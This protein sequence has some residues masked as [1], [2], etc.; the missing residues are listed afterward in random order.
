MRITNVSKWAKI[1][2]LNT[3][4]VSHFRQFCNLEVIIVICVLTAAVGFNLAYLYS[5]FNTSV[6]VSLGSD[7]VM[8]LLLSETVVS[9]M[10]EGW[11]VTD[12]WEGSMGMG[13]PVFHYYQHL[14]HLIVG[15][16]NVV[17]FDAISVGN[18]L[19][20]S[21]Y[22]LISLFPLSMY[23]SLRR[24]GFDP[25]SSAMGGLVASLISTDGTFGFDNSSYI[26]TEI[27]LYTQL[28]GMVLLPLALAWGYRVLQ[29]G[30]GYFWAVAFLSA[31]SMSHL[32]YGYMALLTLGVFAL[33]SPLHF[34]LTKAI[35]TQRSTRS[36][37]RRASRRSAGNQLKPESPVLE[38]TSVPEYIRIQWIRFAILILLVGMVTSYFVV[39]FFLDRTYLNISILDSVFLDSTIYNSLGHAEVLQTLFKGHMFDFSRFP[40]LTIL[41]FIGFVVCVFRWRT[42]IYIVP[43]I[44]FTL[45][46]LLYFGRTTWGPV[47]DLLPMTQDM[48]MYRF[49]GG[50]HL[51]G[52]LLMATALGLSWR[53]AISKGNIWYTAA[54]LILTISVLVPVYL[55]RKE[56]FQQQTRLM[57]ECQP[58]E[59]A[60]YRDMRDLLSALESLPKG[61]VYA[62]IAGPSLG[63]NLPWSADYGIGCSHIQS[64]LYVEGL[65]MMGTRYHPY[66][67]NA[68]LL[69]EFDEARE[70]QYNIFNVR[71]VIAPEG[72][73]FP[74]FVKP[75]G[76]F[77]RHLLYQVETTGYFDLVG[78]EMAFAGSKNDL[79]PAASTWLSSGLPK[80]K[81]HPGIFLDGDDS[82][83]TS[84]PLVDAP[85]SMS[86]G[87]TISV[88]ERGKVVTEEIGTNYFAAD[89]E[90][91]YK[92]ILLLK[93]S[94]HPNWRATVNGAQAEALMFMPGF[95]G[96]ELQPGKYHVRMEYRS[97]QLR[98]IL[99]VLGGLTLVLLAL[100]EFRRERISNW[101][102]RT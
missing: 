72:V 40:S 75:I 27:G 1:F 76:K 89:V 11:N 9:A 12:V 16:I 28:W 10:V 57:Q 36:Q 80:L 53:W 68:K 101:L 95:V 59:E 49:I 19:I 48:H 7:M 82:G 45:W 67:L 4:T 63:D 96:V 3:T 32:L 70:E 37:R 54:A 81:L 14:P 93:A 79:S 2:T 100:C 78:S 102:T 42:G 18:I 8:H 66:S 69:L 33:I 91:G 50:V 30:K 65:D 29:E 43:I 97:R 31:V 98:N 21:T 86:S 17:A 6:N 74:H 5:Y 88:S 85:E 92:S 41:I 24:F 38:S 99:I 56:Y 34:I 60:E 46:I 20:W 47:I 61:R 77:G 84:I 39:P 73:N 22:I 94:Y 64:W 83:E 13:H 71:Y 23:V 15:L 26:Q 52:I 90:V 44:I 58:L 51:G 62:G 35:R 25:L 87:E 55:E